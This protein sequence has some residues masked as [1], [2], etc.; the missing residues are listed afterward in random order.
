MTRV[1]ADNV[2]LAQTERAPAAP[3]YRIDARLGPGVNQ[4]SASVEIHLT[5]Q[6]A[7]Q[8]YRF[9]LGRSFEVLSHEGQGAA[10][11]V[12]NTERP[13][14]G[15]LQAIVVRP[16]S[17][18]D[19]EIVVRV[20]YR[21]TL[22]ATQAPPINSVS[23]QLTELSVDSWW[24]PF[25]HELNVGVLGEARF[26]GVASNAVV[27]STGRVLRTNDQVI[28]TLDRPNDLTLLASPELKTATD[29]RF[30]FYAADTDSETARTYRR[31]GT[32][33]LA[34]LQRSLGSFPGDK[35]NV[36]MVRRASTAGYNRPGYIVVADRQTATSEQALAMSLVHEI[37]HVWWSRASFVNEDYWLVEGPA[38]YWAHRY[39]EEV[40][41]Q[42]SMQPRIAAAKSRAA[43]AGPIIGAGRAGSN[44]VYSKSM[45][46]LMTL[47]QQVG[48]ERFDRFLAQFATRETHTTAAFLSDVAVTFGRDAATRFEASLRS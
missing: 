42:E 14:P 13:F 19:A 21:G 18:D 39:G 2:V 37:A 10:V 16:T 9:L 47:E 30:Q 15:V 43:D 44:A 5:R 41:G 29:G 7:G 4:L 38:E 48:R 34:F 3:R 27:V 8:E 45:L 36:V 35:V 22:S 33:G 6:R 23:P 1:S 46:V 32:R 20:A 12:E 26:S 11:H 24:L 40:F 28:V 17:T 25:P 31:H